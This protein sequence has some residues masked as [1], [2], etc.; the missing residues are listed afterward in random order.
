[1]TSLWSLHV[2]V[3][4]AVGATL[5]PGGLAAGLPVPCLPLNPGGSA[6][7]HMPE[8]RGMCSL[9]F[10]A[11]VWPYST[12]PQHMRQV[13][14]QIQGFTNG[15]QSVFVTNHDPCWV[16]FYYKSLFSQMLFEVESVFSG[17]YFHH[18]YTSYLIIL[19]GSVILSWSLCLIVTEHGIDL[20]IYYPQS[21]WA[22]G[23]C[24]MTP[25]LYSPQY[26]TDPDHIL[27]S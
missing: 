2:W 13:H 21:I 4:S 24:H 7:E 16:Q 25:G 1:M 18:F 23:C 26:L 15:N 11:L 19:V 27:Y 9:K 20:L 14:R 6:T 12:H 3:G 22:G 10:L 5:V 17:L 8:L